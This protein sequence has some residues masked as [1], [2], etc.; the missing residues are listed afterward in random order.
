[1]I[2][3]ESEF[4]VKYSSSV[5]LTDTVND[6]HKSTG[7]RSTAYEHQ[8]IDG[9]LGHLHGIGKEQAQSRSGPYIYGTGTSA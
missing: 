2:P 7:V 9:H 4:L 8:A 3:G 6:T 5:V 1:M